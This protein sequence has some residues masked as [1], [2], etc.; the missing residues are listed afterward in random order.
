MRWAYDPAT[1]TTPAAYAE[2]PPYA[3]AHPAMAGAGFSPASAVLWGAYNTLYDALKVTQPQYQ[4]VG[5]FNLTAYIYRA[6]LFGHTTPES[7]AYSAYVSQPDQE[8]PFY[9]YLA[10]AVDGGWT[11]ES[12]DWALKNANTGEFSAPLISVHG[13]ADA[14]VGLLANAE[15]Y[16]AAVQAYGEP[17][18]HRLYVIPGGPHVDPHA[19][20]LLDYDFDGQ[21]GDQA[22]ADQ[23]TPMQGYAR[24][25]FG[26]LS[27]WVEAGAAPPDSKTVATDTV[28]DVLDPAGIEF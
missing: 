9:G 5:Y 20:G 13:D 23:M 3:A 1:L 4:G 11:P 7:A 6:D 28:N 18:L 10:G 14:L 22:A 8:P 27:A 15:G 24:R 25:A 12:V 2:L 19:D 26:Y 17:A 16:R 21:L